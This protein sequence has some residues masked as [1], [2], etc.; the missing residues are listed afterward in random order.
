MKGL[1][2]PSSEGATRAF[3]DSRTHRI[4]T[5]G[6]PVDR[7][8]RG[9]IWIL[10]IG[11]MQILFG[12]FLGAQLAGEADHALANF[13]GAEPTEVVVL[14]GTEW[15]VAD[16]RTQLERE[17]LQAYV[18]PIGL[19][20]LFI[21]LFFWAR[22]SPLPAL[23]TA[24]ALFVG[25]HILAAVIDPS[26]LVQGVFVKVLFVAALIVAIKASLTDSP[27]SEESSGTATA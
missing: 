25:V 26:T 14:E 27:G 16:L 6:T 3:V 20:V 9:A 22:R 5:G 19:G 11:L 21:G 17:R 4:V 23:I 18:T 15:T 1:E 7:V 2:P 13:A 10:V 12:G 24:L 8:R